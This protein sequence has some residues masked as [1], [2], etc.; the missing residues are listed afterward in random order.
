MIFHVFVHL[1]NT[2][3]FYFTC[4]VLL[5]SD[6]RS[7]GDKIS[8]GVIKCS[9]YMNHSYMQLS[10]VSKMFFF[11]SVV[12]LFKP[13]FLCFSQQQQQQQRYSLPLVILKQVTKSSFRFLCLILK[14]HFI[15]T[16]LNPQF[17]WCCE[18]LK[19]ARGRVAFFSF[20][21]ELPDEQR[22][23]DFGGCS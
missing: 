8:R 15:S 6:S 13:S 20:C 3:I 2:G 7:S 23:N 18:R 22:W 19:E 1:F 17:I 10:D 9:G 5:L 12:V 16:I 4:A 21:F 14:S 11:L